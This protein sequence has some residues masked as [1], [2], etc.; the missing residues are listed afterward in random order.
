MSDIE[1][2]VEARELN[3]VI[4]SGDPII[5]TTLT[6]EQVLSSG[7]TLDI[8]V[9]S[10]EA[11][12]STVLG[13][14]VCASYQ[15]SETEFERD[16][17]GLVRSVFFKGFSE[18]KSLYY[19]NIVAVDPLS[20][21]SHRHNRQIFQEM[22]TKAIV[23]Q[24]LED[25]EL[26]TYFTFKLSAE[27]TEK[28]YCTQMD[29]TDLE[30]IQRLFASE[31]WYYYLQHTESTPNVVVSDSPQGYEDAE[32]DTLSYRDKED[33]P[34]NVLEQWQQMTHIGTASIMLADH[35]ETLA[36]VFDSSDR[37][38]DADT[39][40]SGLKSYHFGDGFEEKGAIRDSAKI[41]M[42]ALDAYRVVSQSQSQISVLSCG[43]VF[44]LD[45]HP[46]DDLNQ[47]YVI[48]AISHSISTSSSSGGAGYSNAFKC[49]PKETPFHPPFI[50]K[51][52]VEGLQ[53]ATV[54]GPSGEKVYA[55][56]NGQI[57][58]QFHWDTLGENDENTSC[59]IPV[60]QPFA[61]NAAGCMFTPQVGDEV[62]VQY[63]DGNPDRP[64]IVG[65]LYNTNNAVP[66]DTPTQ[67]GIMT[68]SGGGLSF[69]EKEGEEEVSILSSNNFSMEVENEA[70]V[71]FKGEYAGEYE[72]A[73]DI[74]CKDAV[75][76]ES[77]DAVELKGDKVVIEAKS[78]LQLKVGSCTVEISS[79]G[80]KV[81]GSKVAISAKGKLEVKGA[82]V[83]LAGQAKVEVKGAMTKVEGSAMNQIKGGAMV[84][85]KGGVSMIN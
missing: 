70:K 11:I 12:E 44:K 30:F 74:Q 79:S 18:E 8:S 72:K 31:G 13:T 73:V 83:K 27:G 46:V 75:A 16:Y 24:V 34:I 82:A 10:P 58:V 85:L 61:S 45:K 38:S 20:L 9:C 53:C 52:K 29:E 15:Q 76:F 6:C 66:Y 5:G 41:R 47:E 60:S 68:A 1:Y 28:E 62:L 80:I 33:D 51:P 81:T 26:G 40:L 2:D 71:S 35:T 22:T 42:E 78:K 69:E 25:A 23:E 14:E 19:Y 59:Y 39:N 65:S 57:K 32:T 7:C 3:V 64:V 50:P 63:I 36:E 84:K 56:D 55:D 43:N 54:T 17:V 77:K 21:L 67:C 49:I 48:I 37:E 4:D